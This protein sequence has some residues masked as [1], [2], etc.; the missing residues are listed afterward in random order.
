MME[1][2]LKAEVIRRVCHTGM[3]DVTAIDFDWLAPVPLNVVADLC[4]IGNLKISHI[5]RHS[6][7][8]SPTHNVLFVLCDR[9]GLPMYTLRCKGGEAWILK[10]VN[11]LDMKAR[12][13]D[14]NCIAT[15]NSKYLITA[16]SKFLKT[17]YAEQYGV[18]SMLANVGYSFAMAASKMRGNNFI[19]TNASIRIE[20]MYDLIRV[21]NGEIPHSAVSS[22]SLAE[23][24]AALKVA[25]VAMNN[26]KAIEDKFVDNFITRKFHAVFHLTGGFGYIVV[27]VAIDP[28]FKTLSEVERAADFQRFTQTGGVQ[29][30]RDYAA[31]AA[32]LPDLDFQF[33]MMRQARMTNN[34]YAKDNDSGDVLGEAFGSNNDLS[35]NVHRYFGHNV[36]KMPTF[37]LTIVEAV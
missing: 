16:F 18:A 15:N 4:R 21:F 6:A 23:I 2:N 27:P 5:G 8:G 30:F 37:Q 19:A 32:A 14:R 20:A 25:T 13:K 1:Q 31:L 34:D 7:I 35:L 22:N 12:G 28:K 26:R 17:S 33:T 29:I 9:I 10:R 36:H 3:M 24:D 11:G